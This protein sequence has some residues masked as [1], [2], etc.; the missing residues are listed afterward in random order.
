VALAGVARGFG[1]I[2]GGAAWGRDEFGLEGDGRERL[3][4]M[5]PVKEYEE[6]VDALRRRSPE[7]ELALRMGL[8]LPHGAF[9]AIDYLASCAPTVGGALDALAGALGLVSSSFRFHADDAPG[10]TRITIVY[11]F[12]LPDQNFHD[13]Y[14]LG[15]LAARFGPGGIGRDA[16]MRAF[17]TRAE[18]ERASAFEELLGC[19]IAWRSARP[20]LEFPP[21][22]GAQPNECAD[23]RLAR[24]LSELLGPVVHR[25][26]GRSILEDDVRRWLDD[27][28]PASK[29]S[30]SEVSRG[31][32]M[33]TR[34]LRRKLAASG[35]TY[36]RLLDEVRA[37][38]SQYLLVGGELTHVEI[39]GQVGFSDQ[40]SWSR[41]FKRWTGLPPSEW[42]ALNA[43]V[44]G[45]N[46]GPR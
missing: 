24:I 10:S 45:G 1:G 16:P 32:G 19:P 36:Q 20:S 27:G 15:A 37:T 29:T 34:T 28:M 35:W 46:R 39:A 18:P 33:S 42:L 38:R 8:S 14:A 2:P 44:S 7:E 43:Q 13:E 11:Q 40:A 41:A 6:F 4:E 17:L 31:L 12:A 25:L 5:S 9:G 26:P 30:L 22:L 3:D 21:G 23:P